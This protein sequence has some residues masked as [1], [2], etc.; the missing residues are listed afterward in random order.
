MLFTDGALSFTILVCLPW[1]FASCL[2]WDM[3]RSSRFLHTLYTSPSWFC[4]QLDFFVYYTQ[5]FALT[6]P[7]I[8]V[9]IFCRWYHPKMTRN[10][11]EVLLLTNGVE[12]N[13][14]IRPSHSS[15]GNFA[16]SVRYAWDAQDRTQ[17]MNHYFVGLFGSEY[18]VEGLI[19]DHLGNLKKWP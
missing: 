1:S 3:L 2:V 16:I 10:T 18:T 6:R 14:L 5:K 11:A 7:L 17:R 19:S 9:H 4:I 12:G 8:Y 13:F 15:A